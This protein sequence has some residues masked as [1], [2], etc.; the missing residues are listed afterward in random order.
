MGMQL[1]LWYADL[2]SF[3]HMPVNGI[4]GSCGGSTINCLRNCHTDFRSA[5]TSLHCHQQWT[6]VPLSHSFTSNHLMLEN[7]P[8]CL[9]FQVQMRNTR[10][11]RWS[12]SRHAHRVKLGFELQHVGSSAPW[13]SCS[14]FSHL[15]VRDFRWKRISQNHGLL[16]RQG[17][18][19][20]RDI[21]LH[22]SVL[23]TLCSSDI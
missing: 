4:A 9:G 14:S 13:W 23:S 16:D 1:S 8:Y 15:W 6:R 17:Y 3:G 5:H 19:W 18:N 21:H 10:H 12:C 7:R 11:K 22:A 20:A 2:E